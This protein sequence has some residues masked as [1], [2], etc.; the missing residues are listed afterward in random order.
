MIQII[1]SKM[2]PHD[3]A[4]FCE[5]YYKTMVKFVVDV[6][7]EVMAVGGE[8]HS[9]AEALLL[10][11]GSRQSDL[12]GGNFFPWNPPG[13]RLE[14]TSFINIRPADDNVSMEVICEITRKKIAALA[15][16]LLLSDSEIL[17]ERK[18]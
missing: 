10:T 16:K 13:Q 7:K 5:A 9:D 14:F 6:E 12:W 1:E 15:E 3:L 18:I 17:P 4:E 2:P 11:Q 8:L